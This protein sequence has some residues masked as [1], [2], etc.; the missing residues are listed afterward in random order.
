MSTYDESNDFDLDSFMNQLSE[1]GVVTK[2]QTIPEFWYPA[3]MVGSADRPMFNLNYGCTVPKKG[4]PKFPA[5]LPTSVDGKYTYN[6]LSIN[7]QTSSLFARN[8]AKRE[9]DPY[10]RIEGGKGNCADV[11][12]N[13]TV[14]ANVGLDLTKSPGFVN[15]IGAIL[16]QIGLAEPMMNDG[17][18]AGYKL[19]T[20]IIHTL[21]A[22]IKD[23]KAKIIEAKE[24]SGKWHT[25]ER[26][27]DERCLPFMLAEWQ[28]AQLEALL[29]DPNGDKD[30]LK[31]VIRVGEREHYS[32]DGSK[33]NYVLEFAH[34]F[35]VKDTVREEG[36]D[37]VF[38]LTR[39]GTT[40]TFDLMV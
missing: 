17:K 37:T 29:K 4:K 27:D 22:P 39:G 18:F 15:F 6:T 25:E 1:E 11:N 28:L 13:L 40:S 24:A 19:D 35:E 9:T 36:N 32:G 10:I 23:V 33:E 5:D 14:N 34:W 31:L 21:Y 20:S 16:E 7:C 38:D 3:Y 30:L 8:A 26:K 12:L 2:A